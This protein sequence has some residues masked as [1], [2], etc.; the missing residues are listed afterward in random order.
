LATILGSLFVLRSDRT[1]PHHLAIA[2]AFARGA[3]HGNPA[4]GEPLVMVAV[5]S[6]SGGGK[7]SRNSAC[8]VLAG[9]PPICPWTS[10]WVAACIDATVGAQRDD[11]GLRTACSAMV[12]ATTAEQFLW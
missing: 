11:K 12:V 9:Y 4:G 7:G 1:N 5:M 8:V 6:R 2:L 3:F 10:D